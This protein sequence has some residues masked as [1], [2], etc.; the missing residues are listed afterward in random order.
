[1]SRFSLDT[2]VD[3]KSALSKLGLGDIFSKTKADFSRIT[4]M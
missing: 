4:S 1:M 3:L 2:E